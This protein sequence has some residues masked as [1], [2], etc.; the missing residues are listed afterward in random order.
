MLCKSGDVLGNVPEVVKQPY[1]N[2]MEVEYQEAGPEAR[3]MR[4]LKAAS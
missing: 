4:A 2:R 3:L 1:I